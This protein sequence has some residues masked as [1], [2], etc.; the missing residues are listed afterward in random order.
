MKKLVLGIALVIGMIGNA[1][2]IEVQSEY[3]FTNSFVDTS[4]IK[5][6]VLIDP[7][8]I[9]SMN[10]V[11]WNVKLIFDLDQKILQ[12]NEFHF[13]DNK[14]EF[15]SDIEI[16]YIEQTS[17]IIKLTLNDNNFWKYCNIYVDSKKIIFFNIET[18]IQPN[19]VYGIYAVMF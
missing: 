14:F 4:Q 16:S 18:N 10:I 19:F 8:D 6:S 9:S 7:E 1:Q 2:K 5:Q 11:P 13:S 17:D 15:I 3:F 12:V